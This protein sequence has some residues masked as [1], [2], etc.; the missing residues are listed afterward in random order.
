MGRKATAAGVG[1]VFVFVVDSFDVVVRVV[2]SVVVGLTGGSG[3]VGDDVAHSA[4][5]TS[6]MDICRVYQ[7]C[8][9]FAY[10][11]TECPGAT[12]MAS[13]K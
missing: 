1:V 2:V 13:S 11:K 4:K 9:C 3:G 10:T 12:A 7:P 5:T 6:T 8:R